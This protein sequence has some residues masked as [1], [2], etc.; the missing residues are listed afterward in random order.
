MLRGKS[1]AC[2]GVVITFSRSAPLDDSKY[3]NLLETLLS[4]RDQNFLHFD[5][6]G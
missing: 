1:C 5:L 2:L 6:T 4:M 3:D